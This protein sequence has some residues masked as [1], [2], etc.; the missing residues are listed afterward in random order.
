MHPAAPDFDPIAFADDL[1][2]RRAASIAESVA[3]WRAWVAVELPAVLAL[4]DNA[5]AARPGMFAWLFPTGSPSRLEPDAPRIAR[6]ELATAVEGEPALRD[7]LE[8]AFDRAVLF[9]G[10][11]EADGVLIWR[12]GPAAWA[13]STRYDRRVYRMLRCLHV[14]GLSDQAGMLMALLQHELGADARR[15]DPLSWYHHQVA[16]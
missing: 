11:V 12:E 5:L 15:A 2:A 3:R 13:L 4:P 8:R 1:A 16:S 9:L 7:A 14:A 10:L 6:R